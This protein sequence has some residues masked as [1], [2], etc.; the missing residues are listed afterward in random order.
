M[1]CHQKV[2]SGVGP[3]SSAAMGASPSTV[4]RHSSSCGKE[5]RNKAGKW[6]RSSLRAGQAESNGSAASMGRLENL[7]HPAPTPPDDIC[8][9][10]FLFAVCHGDHPFG[11]PKRHELFRCRGASGWSHGQAL[12]VK[13]IGC[14]LQSTDPVFPQAFPAESR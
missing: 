7:L 2:A 6:A 13:T 5:T 9:C 11:S 4:P 3:G 12:D 1:I 8:N 10:I 14:K